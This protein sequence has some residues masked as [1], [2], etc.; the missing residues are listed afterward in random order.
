LAIINSVA[1]TETLR[2]N[3]NNLSIY[4]STVIALTI[5]VTSTIVVATAANITAAAT[6]ATAHHHCLHLVDCFL[7]SP[8]S[9][10]P[11]Q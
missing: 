9:L 2:A 10:L 4:T 8:P 1:T 11:Y 3:L 7:F 5:V 6:V